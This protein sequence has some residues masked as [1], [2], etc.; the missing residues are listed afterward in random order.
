LKKGFHPAAPCF[1]A[2]HPRAIASPT[3]EL[4]LAGL[5]GI[6]KD[7]VS[8]TTYDGEH[9]DPIAQIVDGQLDL[10]VHAGA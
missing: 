4:F 5:S 1:P 3:R 9:C 7:R 10:R 8:S 2:Q 6:A